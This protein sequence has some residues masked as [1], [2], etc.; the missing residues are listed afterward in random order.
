MPAGQ[1]ITTPKHTIYRRNNKHVLSYC[2][3]EIVEDKSKQHGSS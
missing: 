1:V 2:A 3:V